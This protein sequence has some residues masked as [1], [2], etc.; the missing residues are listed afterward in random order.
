[1]RLYGE[2]IKCDEVSC[3]GCHIMEKTVKE[4]ED[5]INHPNHYKWFPDKEVIDVIESVLTEEEWRG[6][7]K[8]NSLKYRLRA[9]KKGDVIEDIG[10]AEVYE[11]W[12]SV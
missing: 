6:Y 1:M 10:K 9:G 11:G 12:V 4:I 7:C 8:G 3:E 2:C 5:V